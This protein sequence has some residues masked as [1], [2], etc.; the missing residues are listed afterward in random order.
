MRGG[1]SPP[2]K[3]TTVTVTTVTVTVT[4]DD[5]DDDLLRYFAAGGGRSGVRGYKDRTCSSCFLV[6]LLPSSFFLS[7]FFFLPLWPYPRQ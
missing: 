7:S 5:D 3:T 1:G 4:T 2:A 6:A